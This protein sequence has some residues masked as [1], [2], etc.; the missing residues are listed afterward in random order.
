MSVCALR[1]CDPN[2][3]GFWFDHI[4]DNDA[5]SALR[6]VLAANGRHS[7][8]GRHLVNEADEVRGLHV[9]LEGWA[10]LYKSLPEGQRQ[11]IDIAVPGNFFNLSS[12]DGH[13]AVIGLETVTTAL[14]AAVPFKQ[15]A[16][17]EATLPQVARVVQKE[18][19]ATRS[20]ISERM[21][22]LGRGSAEER[23]AYAFLEL[24]VRTGAMRDDTIRSC[25][26]PVTQSHLGD[27]MG[28]TSVHVCRT[29][30]RMKRDGV[31]A[32]SNHIDLCKF[33]VAALEYLAG[34][35]VSELAREIMP[36]G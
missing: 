29:L 31:M 9:I 17:L 11:I 7:P 28:L 10:V 33:D 35:S 12:A 3:P 4:L 18:A 24:G 36:L 16:R 25:Q 30:R 22:R 27:F 19:G 20:R 32:S 1:E 21:L 26:I 5:C 15:W 6:A 23:L 34:I 14:I 13:T 2:L 8:S